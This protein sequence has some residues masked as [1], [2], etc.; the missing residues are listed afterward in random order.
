MHSSQSTKKSRSFS[1]RENQ[2]EKNYP[3]FSLVEAELLVVMDDYS[4]FPVVVEVT[5][6]AFRNV[7]PELDNILSQYGILEVIE[8]D[9]G[10]PFNGEPFADYAAKMGFRHRK[11]T[12]LWPEANGEVERFMKTLGKIIRA[13]TAGGTNC[14][15]FY[16]ISGL[17]IILQ[18]VSRH[19]LSYLVVCLKH[20][21][22]TCCIATK[23]TDDAWKK[24]PTDVVM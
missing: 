17:L 1:T 6:T 14:T 21:F 19:L 8:T 4:K 9:N 24:T 20:V 2:N 10:P 3:F 18:R 16:A 12:S 7:K 15:I 11:I 13:A 5:S 23:T 22:L